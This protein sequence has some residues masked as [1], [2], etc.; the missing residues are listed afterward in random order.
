MLTKIV[1]LTVNS[2]LY[3]SEHQQDMSQQVS[4]NLMSTDLQHIDSSGFYIQF[5]KGFKIQFEKRFQTKN[6]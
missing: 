4:T 3:V 1:K 6:G 5:E 2:N